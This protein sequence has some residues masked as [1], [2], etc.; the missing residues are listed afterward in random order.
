MSAE[1]TRY[2]CYIRYGPQIAV[3]R[4]FAHHEVAFD[5]KLKFSRQ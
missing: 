5:A 2:R 4:Q 3:V 1:F